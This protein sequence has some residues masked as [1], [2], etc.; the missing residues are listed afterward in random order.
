MLG[1]AVGAAFAGAATISL[2]QLFVGDA[3][4]PRFV[5]LGSALLLPDWFRICTRMAAGGRLRAEARDRVVVVASAEDVSTLAREL[6]GLPERPASIAA[7]MTVT[8]R[9]EDSRVGQEWVSTGR[10]R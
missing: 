8:Q 6:Q 9:S 5:V 1:S 2:V 4:L 3:L 7:S 10:Y